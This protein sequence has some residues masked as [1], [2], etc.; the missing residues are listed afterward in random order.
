VTHIRNQTDPLRT[1]EWNFRSVQK[2]VAIAI[3]KTI[4]L[5]K[6]SKYSIS[7]VLSSRDVGIGVETGAASWIVAE[8][9][10]AC[11]STVPAGYDHMVMAS[12]R[13]CLIH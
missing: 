13:R 3:V 8:A 6:S 1:R 2:A 4:Y 10:N 9:V 7:G 12:I 5:M 11:H